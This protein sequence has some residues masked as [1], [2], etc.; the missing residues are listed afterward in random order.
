MFLN[1]P[2]L[3]RCYRVIFQRWGGRQTSHILKAGKMIPPICWSKPENLTVLTRWSKGLLLRERCMHTFSFLGSL[4]VI[5][6]YGVRTNTGWRRTRG[7]NMAKNSQAIKAILPSF[8][9]CPKIPIRL[10]PVLVLAPW[11]TIRIV[12]IT[13]EWGPN[14]LLPP[15]IH[16]T[17][18]SDSV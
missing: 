9:I 7:L 18:R 4:I 5:A 12:E 2:L 14:R 8:P 6:V 11:T 15:N 13:V 10:H 17:S 3:K 16:I 1:N